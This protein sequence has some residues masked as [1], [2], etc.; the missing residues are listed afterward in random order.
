MIDDEWEK[1]MKLLIFMEI[2][3]LLW[4]VS[5]WLG[6][7]SSHVLCSGWLNPYDV[8]SSGCKEDDGYKEWS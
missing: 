1:F 8:I 2:M 7:G 6:Y 5:Q 3:T 4:S